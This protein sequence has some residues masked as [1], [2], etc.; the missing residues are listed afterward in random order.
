[1]EFVLVPREKNK[2]ADFL[3]NDALDQEGRTQKLI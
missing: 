1:V 2:E 3:A